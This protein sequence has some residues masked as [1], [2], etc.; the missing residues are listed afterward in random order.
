MITLH[1]KNKIYKIYLRVQYSHIK[2][3]SEFRAM[4]KKSIEAYKN[5]P[6]YKNYGLELEKKSILEVCRIFGIISKKEE[7][8][9]KV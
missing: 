7:K 2:S 1:E 3:E 4:I 5:N 8:K 6:Q 9:W